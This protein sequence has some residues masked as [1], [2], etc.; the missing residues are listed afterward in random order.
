MKRLYFFQKENP[1]KAMNLI[2]YLTFG[3]ILFPRMSPFKW[4]II[5]LN[6]QIYS[7][8]QQF[9]P[10]HCWLKSLTM[11][12]WVWLWGW[13]SSK[14]QL[15]AGFSRWATWLQFLWR[16][17]YWVC[18]SQVKPCKLKSCSKPIYL[19]VVNNY[20][21]LEG[22][23]VHGKYQMMTLLMKRS[24][25]NVLSFLKALFIF[26]L[27]WLW[28]C[29]TLNSFHDMIEAFSDPEITNKILKVRRLGLV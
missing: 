18:S 7:S 2:L 17:H 14:C 15:W 16:N 24:S 1:A 25:I 22:A 29:T 11:A 23:F 20:A 12:V 4:F 21:V 13:V 26:F 5:L 28:S 19:Y 3:Q 6:S 10:N 9:S 27:K 8:T